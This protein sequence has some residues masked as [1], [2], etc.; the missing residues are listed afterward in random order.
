VAVLRPE[1]VMYDKPMLEQWKRVLRD[2]LGIDV[3]QIG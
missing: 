2:V 3:R 1:G